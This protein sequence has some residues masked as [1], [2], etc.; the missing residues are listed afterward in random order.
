MTQKMF[1]VLLDPDMGTP[2]LRW[3]N[4]AD[5]VPHG[6]IS[7][8]GND[9]MG[10]GSGFWPM[11]V[12]VFAVSA[13]WG[14][15][16]LADVEAA[17]GRNLWLI[18]DRCKAVFES[19][20]REAFEFQPVEIVERDS[21][22]PLSGLRY[23]LCDV[24]R[25]L[26]ALDEEKSKARVEILSNGVKRVIPRIGSEVFRPGIV[27]GN[28]AFRLMYAPNSKYVT[29][30]FTD[31]IRTAGLSGFMLSDGGHIDA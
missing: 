1:R 4:P 6:H 11:E 5:P 26:D 13:E 9:A 18:S 20:D 14:R 22:R 7:D 3:M 8:R 15:L 17:V 31:R 16:P 2:G 24:V 28:E 27:R 21:Q 10:I 19:L 29:E 23:W 25:Y 30:Q 12:P